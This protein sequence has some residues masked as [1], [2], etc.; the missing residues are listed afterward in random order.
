M[1]ADSRKQIENRM[2]SMTTRK[3]AKA[4]ISSQFPFLFPPALVCFLSLDA[5]NWKQRLFPE[6]ILPMKTLGNEAE[7]REP[8]TSLSFHAVRPSLFPF[9]FPL[10]G[11]NRK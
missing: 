10:H 7:T 1:P 5:E 6:S 2:S 9:L 11:F 3:G 8:K 4:V